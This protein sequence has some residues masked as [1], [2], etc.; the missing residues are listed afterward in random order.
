M[1]PSVGQ[2]N[3]GLCTHLGTLLATCHPGAPAQSPT[4]GH[5]TGKVWLW[6]EGALALALH[7][8]A[9]GH[10]PAG[11]SR[12]QPQGSQET[13]LSFQGD[14]GGPLVCELNRIWVQIGIVS[15]GRG[16]LFPVYPTVY[17]RV[18]YFSTWIHHQIAHTPPPLQP[19]PILSC[20]LG[21]SVSVLVTMM[22]FL[23]ML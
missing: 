20:T 13:P 16:C 10:P 17:A 23:P 9:L 21:T 14:S 1:D 3:P 5:G 6:S 19:L 11:G 8:W 12:C 4:A 7:C 2:S 18:S 15:W 22:A